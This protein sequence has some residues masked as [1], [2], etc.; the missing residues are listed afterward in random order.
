M[1]PAA[2]F[3]LLI[4]A[5]IALAG[6]LSKVHPSNSEPPLAEKEA[7]EEQAKSNDAQKNAKPAANPALSGAD[8]DKAF[9]KY[10]EGAVRVALEV[11]KRGKMTLELYPKAAPETVKHFTEL[12]KQHFYDGLLFHRYVENFVIQGG[13][14]KSKEVDGSKIADITPDEVGQ[15]YG[16]GSNGSGKTVPLEAN[17]PHLKYSIGLARSQATDSGDSQ[18]YINLNDNASLDSQYCVFGRI[19][20]GQNVADTLRQGDRI[21]SITVL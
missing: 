7:A 5:A 11:E 4:V 6:I 13:D 8:R 21:K 17:L 9:D 1:R 3:I 2:G 19:V 12:A 14:P 10:K 20:D 15:Q 18:F 16:L